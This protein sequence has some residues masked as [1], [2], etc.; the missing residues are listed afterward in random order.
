[1]NLIF[2]CLIHKQ[3]AVQIMTVSLITELGQLFPPGTSVYSFIIW[4]NMMT[5]SMCNF[6]TCEEM[7]DKG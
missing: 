3:F 6:K 7:I 1:M 4:K 2:I 5:F